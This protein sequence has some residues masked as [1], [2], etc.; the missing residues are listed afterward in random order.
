[1][2][3]TELN[4]E[5]AKVLT[6]LTLQIYERLRDDPHTLALFE[7]YADLADA[8]AG[9]F[10]DGVTIGSYDDAVRS[11][12]ERAEDV[13]ERHRSGLPVSLVTIG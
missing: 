4:L 5:A 10:D 13:L 6:A 11:S 9:G 2:L 3:L 1:M 8:L 7:A 12:K